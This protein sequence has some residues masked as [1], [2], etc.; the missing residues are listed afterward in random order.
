M[1]YI[2]A[3]LWSN[4]VYALLFWQFTNSITN[5]EQ[6]K[7]FYILFGFLGQSG[8]F[9][10]AYILSNLSGWA[11]K[12]ISDYSLSIAK[13]ALCI[14]ILTTI[15]LILG[16]I[17]MCALYLI[18]TKLLTNA[19]RN[20]IKFSH[21][22]QHHISLR[23]SVK[24]IFQ[25]NYIRLIICI[26]VC[27]GLAINLV[28]GPWKARVAIAYPSPEQYMTFVGS[29]LK[30]NGFLV[31][32]IALMG[33]SIIR[34]L[35]WLPVALL[36]PSVLLITGM[37]FFVV[38]NFGFAQQILLGLVVTDPLLISVHVGMVQNVLVKATKYTLFD[39]TKEMAYVPLDPETKTKGKAISDILGT[40]MGKSIGSFIQ[41]SILTL[42]PNLQYNS[43][44]VSIILMFF[45]VLACVIW[46]VAVLRLSV[47]YSEA[48]IGSAK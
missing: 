19:E 8:L 36:T 18:S 4:V 14:Q 20:Q 7:R 45:L 26:L 38:G 33:S 42:M 48:L 35:G 15:V 31:V 2:I 30:Y 22:Q 11:A 37:I 47:S 16:F 44:P 10:S 24:F 39:A 21:K 40:K 34:L 46:I 1:F 32:I 13:T 6:S 23:E 25:S 41:L 28:E 27:Y 5:A 3:E 12:L 17:I 29:Y 9:I 43:L